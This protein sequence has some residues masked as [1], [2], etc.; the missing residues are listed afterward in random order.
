MPVF[1]TKL[2]HSPEAS[3]L[4]ALTEPS[5]NQ[6]LTAVNDETSPTFFDCLQAGEFALSLAALSGG[7][8]VAAADFAV[9][10]YRSI[11]GGESWQKVAT[12]TGTTDIFVPCKLRGVLWKWKL[13]TA[14]ANPTQVRART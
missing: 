5:I 11:D 6:T 12:Y 14:G 8:L 1:G 13:K 9:D 2:Q 3:Q 7:Q 10:A 4:A